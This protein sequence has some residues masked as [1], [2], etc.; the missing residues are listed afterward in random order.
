MGKAPLSSSSLVLKSDSQT[1][2]SLAVTFCQTLCD[3][4]NVLGHFNLDPIS[5][6]IR[7]VDHL[8]IGLFEAVSF[9]VHRVARLGDGRGSVAVPVSVAVAVAIPI[10]VLI[11]VAVSVSA[12][13]P[14]AISLA[15]TFHRLKLVKSKINPINWSNIVDITALEDIFTSIICSKLNTLVTNPIPEVWFEALV[16]LAI[17][18]VGIQTMKTSVMMM[19]MILRFFRNRIPS[20]SKLLHSQSGMHSFRRKTECHY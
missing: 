13:V 8:V 6:L 15:A 20:Q 11:P 3:D 19:M 12:S 1:R 7:V 16:C 2:G 4:A 5:T 14:I 18:L 9:A 10:P 17:G